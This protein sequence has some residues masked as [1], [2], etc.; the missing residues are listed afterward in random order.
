MSVRGDRGAL[1]VE[2]EAGCPRE[3]DYQAMRTAPESAK[4]DA[5]PRARGISSTTIR[6]QLLGETSCLAG[7]GRDGRT[8]M[9]ALVKVGTKRPSGQATLPKNDQRVRVR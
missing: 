5:K 9:S 1:E 6:D 7:T 4:A 2:L 8:G 3:R